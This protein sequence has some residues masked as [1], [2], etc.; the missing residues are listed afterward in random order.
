MKVIL[1]C[2]LIFPITLLAQSPKDS[3]ITFTDIIT[4]DSVKKEELYDRARQWFNASFKD[5]R[6]VIRVADKE[7][8]ELLAKGVI[9]SQHWYRSLGKETLIPIG[10]N[11]DIAIYLKDGKYKYE[12][13]RFVDAAPDP[14]TYRGPLTF[15]NEFP[16]K[17]YRKKEIMDKIWRSQQEELVKDMKPIIR[18]LIE[19]M[20]KPKSDF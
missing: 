17:G 4:V 5:A 7:A 14:A 20:A 15:T 3:I 19:F 11:F 13:T 2:C 1:L 6:N 9:I 8:G 10:Y 12:F 18:D 16:G